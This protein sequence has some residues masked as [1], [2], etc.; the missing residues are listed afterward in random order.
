[1]WPLESSGNCPSHRNH[2]LNTLLLGTHA[3][4]SVFSPLLLSPGIRN[5][6]LREEGFAVWLLVVQGGRTG[7]TALWEHRRSRTWKSILLLFQFSQLKGFFLREM[8]CLTFSEKYPI[9]L[10][11]KLP[12][13]NNLV[14]K[15]IYQSNARVLKQESINFIDK[16]LPRG[17]ALP[18][19]L[20]PYI[21]SCSK[22]CFPLFSLTPQSFSPHP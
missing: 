1:M 13:C 14:S 4:C 12:S 19:T 11:V 6:S 15:L 5:F 2:T 21:N 16:N 7:G 18:C 3:A 10:M 8:S 17:Q 20:P 22:L 9:H